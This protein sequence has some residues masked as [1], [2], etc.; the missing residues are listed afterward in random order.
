V[1]RPLHIDAP[2]RSSTPVRTERIETSS[3]YLVVFIITDG[4]IQK[5]LAQ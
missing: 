5:L 2:D 4:A 3:D 1:G